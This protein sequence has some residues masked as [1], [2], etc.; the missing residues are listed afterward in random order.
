M[1]KLFGC[2]DHHFGHENIIKYCNR[3]ISQDDANLLDLPGPIPNTQLTALDDAKIM[4]ARHNSVVS[5][6]DIVVLAGDIQASK[7]GRLWI[8]KIIPKLKGRKILV[9]GNHD[10][11]SN[12]EFLAMGFESVHEVL[13]IGNWC[14]CHYPNHPDVVRLCKE[15]NLVLCAGH[16]HKPFPDYADGVTRINLA[17]DVAGRTPTF[18]GELESTDNVSTHNSNKIHINYNTTQDYE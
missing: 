13:V 14:F 12:E 9:R 3:E 4:I 18:I 11:Q 5:D 16:T 6:N 2:S 1:V 7:Q 8:P 10:H 17:L 15:R